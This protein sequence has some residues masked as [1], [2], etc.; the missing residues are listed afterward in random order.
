MFRRS[1]SIKLVD[2]FG[3]RIGVDISWFLI[4]FVLIY[5]LSGPFRTTLH[6]SDSVAY[7][8]TVASVLLLFASLIVHELGHALVARREGVEVK[9]ID[10][11]LFGGITQM[12]RD[13]TNPG[14]E[15][16]IAAAGPAA[17]LAVIVLCLIIDL[18]VVGPHRLL[19]AAL[20]KSNVK[21]T[22]VLLCMS[23]LLVMNVIVFVFNLI[24]AFPLDGGRI[25]RALVW[26]VTGDQIRATRVSARLGQGFGW[27]LGAAG[28]VLL[29][30][31]RDVTGIWFAA[32]GY[33][34][35][36]SA[37]GTLA[38]TAITQRVADVLVSD[39]M[40]R[41]P[42]AIPADTPVTEALDAYFLR[43]GWAWFPVVDHDGHFVGIVR[44]ERVEAARDGGEG[45]LTVGAVVEDGGAGTWFVDQDR[46]LNE[47]LNSEPLG[48]LGALMA[49]DREGTLRGVITIEHV[50][51]ALQSALGSPVR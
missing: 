7:L 2:A 34:I 32:M 42:V 1:G 11:F 45:W 23:W 51:R 25:A 46:P 13:S 12:S 28:I 40:D 5:L 14:E 17:T 39:I 4:L 21:V 15:F 50:R 43:Y 30:A 36:Q 44:Q 22:P 35:A 37:R 47:L 19:D 10:L 49:V 20:L 8:T 27:L 9:R 48:R 31:L 29:I 18:L 6:S 3:I 16:R 26:R 24:P 38:Q 33:L 41:E